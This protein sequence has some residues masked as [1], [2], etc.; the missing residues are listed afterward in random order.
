MPIKTKFHFCKLFL[1]VPFHAWNNTF[2]DGLGGKDTRDVLLGKVVL[3]ETCHAWGLDLTWWA[4][5]ALLGFASLPLTS[6]HGL[7]QQPDWA[8]YRLGACA[9]IPGDQFQSLWGR[10]LNSLAS[11]TL[12]SMIIFFCH[13]WLASSNVLACP[14]GSLE[15]LLL[16]AQNRPISY[17]KVLEKNSSACWCS[18]LENTPQLVCVLV[19]LPSGRRG[20]LKLTISSHM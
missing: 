18:C 15:G 4:A 16:V 5:S 17:Q 8:P 3:E 19:E 7:C 6:W 13:W 1:A 10:G 2:W 14:W 12:G 11:S 20:P 9:R